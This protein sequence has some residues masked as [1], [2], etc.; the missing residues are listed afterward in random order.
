MRLRALLRQCDR[1]LAKSRTALA[2]KLLE[3]AVG[4]AARAY[5]PDDPDRAWFHQ[6]VAIRFRRLGRVDEAERHF[7]RALKILAWAERPADTHVAA[8]L[9]GLASIYLDQER[10]EEAEPLCWQSLDILDEAL[11]SRHLHVA[12]AVRTVAL[13]YHL[14]GDIELAEPLYR[15]ALEVQEESLGPNHPTVAAGRESLARLCD[16]QGRAAD[17]RDLRASPKAMIH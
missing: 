17:A 1:A 3:K 4:G 10:Y 13:L 14:Q 11:G 5:P 6:D 12:S 16:A 15:R 9:H 8:L 7:K 2:L